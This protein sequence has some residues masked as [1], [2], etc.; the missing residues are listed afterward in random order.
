MTDNAGRPT[1]NWIQ[2]NSKWIGVLAVVGVGLAYVLNQVN[3][4]TIAMW[5][6]KDTKRAIRLCII[7]AYI[8]AD[9]PTKTDIFT[10]LK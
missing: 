4:E 6:V 10:C 2:S 3:P 9:P 1:L 8:K 5:K 7:E